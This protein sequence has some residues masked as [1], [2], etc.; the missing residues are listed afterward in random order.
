[1]SSRTRSR[2]EYLNKWSGGCLGDKSRRRSP[3]P[4][5]SPAGHRVGCRGGPGVRGPPPPRRRGSAPSARWRRRGCRRGSS[6]RRAAW[7]GGW[8]SRGWSCEPPPPSW[9]LRG[10]TP[11][12]RT[13]SSRAGCAGPRC[14]ARLRPLRSAFF[15]W[16]ATSRAVEL[17]QGL[18][19]GQ[20]C[21][22]RADQMKDNFWKKY[23]TGKFLICHLN[24]FSKIL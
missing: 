15:L 20:C 9:G 5:P 17:K 3:S 11:R 22:Q 7:R 23:S 12:P 24:M 1:M 21:S 18:T 4:P 14:S 16:K 13:G 2:G 10:R 8:R 6:P 19:G